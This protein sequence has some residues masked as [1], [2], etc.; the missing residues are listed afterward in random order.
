MLKE[1]MGRMSLTV[2]Q[3]F[4]IILMEDICDKKFKAGVT[5]CNWAC[6]IGGMVVQNFFGCVLK[7]VC[8]LDNGGVWSPQ[9]RVYFLHQVISPA[10][11]DQANSPVRN[12]M[13]T[14]SAQGVGIGLSV[15]FDS[16]LA[17]ST[18]VV[19]SISPGEAAARDGS[20][21]LSLLQC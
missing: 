4:I 8:P 15:E 9:A 3:K 2:C 13:S 1:L 14:H 7:T 6:A 18:F 5:Q 12:A 11:R 19:S 16:G 20:I 17:G 10:Q 21:G